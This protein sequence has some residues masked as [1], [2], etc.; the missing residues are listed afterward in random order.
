MQEIVYDSIVIGAGQSGLASAYY[1]QNEGLSFVVLEQSEHL[2]SWINYYESLKLFSPAR[3]SSLPGFPFPG[4]PEGY[5]TC[6]KVV[7]YLRSYADHFHFPIRYHTS[8]QHVSSNEELFY[9]TTTKQEV[10]RA[11]SVICASGPFRKPHLPSLPGQEQYR[12]TVLHSIDYRQANT[13]RGQ[14][15]AVVGAGNSAVQIAHELAQITD[16]TLTSRR[17]IQF[18]PQ[19]LLGKDIHYWMDLLQL[20]QSRLGKWLLRSRSSGVLDTGV[21]RKAIEN[22]AP[23][24]RTMFQR[25]GEHGVFWED[26]TYENMDTVIFATGFIPNSPYLMDLGALDENGSP[27][28]KHGISMKFK[29]LYFV[30]LPWQNSLASATLRGSGKDAKMVVR[31]LLTHLITPTY[32]GKSKRAAK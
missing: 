14:K 23:R 24:H 22:N 30:G 10:L 3:Y 5:P 27:I 6:D 19:R 18:A 28:Q 20:D 25:F 21:Y 4:D 1:L 31:D 29:G 2:G 32:V 13:Y 9:V 17:P 11:R 15:V 16:V 12:G 7:Q 8:V 26:G